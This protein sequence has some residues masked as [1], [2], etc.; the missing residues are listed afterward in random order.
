MIALI[1]FWALA[2]RVWILDGPKIPLMFIALWL[3]GFFVFPILH[4]SGYF[5]LS[6]EAILAVILLLVERYKS[7]S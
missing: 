5:F 4:W 1:A 2:I 6:F 3:A 7:L